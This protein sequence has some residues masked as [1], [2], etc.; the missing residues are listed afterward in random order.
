MCCFDGQ[1]RLASLLDDRDLLALR[2]VSPKARTWVDAVMHK[3]P[4]NVFT[5]YVNEVSD[6]DIVNKNTVLD[7]L[8]DEETDRI[9]FFRRLYISDSSFFSHPLIPSFLCT[10]GVQIHTVVRCFCHFYEYSVRDG[11]EAEQVAFYQALPN[12]TQLSTRWLGDRIPDGKMPA[13][14]RLQLR[15]LRCNYINRTGKLNFDFLQQLPNLSHFWL[16]EM[17]VEAYV[18]VLC[19]LGSY[20]EAVNK[21][22]VSCGRTRTIF[23]D[24]DCIS[25]EIFHDEWISNVRVKRLLRELAVADG[26]IL[27]QNMPIQLLDEAIRLFRRQRGGNL[28][29][30]SFGKC[31]RSLYGFSSSLYEVELPNMRKL[32]VTGALGGTSKN[33]DYS[34]TVRWPKLKNVKVQS[35]PIMADDVSYIAKLVFGSGVHRPSVKR[36]H[37]DMKTLLSLDSNEAH[38]LLLNFPNLTCLSLWMEEEEDVGLFHSLMGMLPTCCPKIRFSSYTPLFFWGTRTSLEFM[39][40]VSTLLLLPCYSSQASK[41]FTSC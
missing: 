23:V 31:I 29:L 15:R 27:I 41:W 11:N 17:R 8:M 39:R 5:L 40:K 16:P 19:A 20:F 32:E 18:K 25:D 1:E 28:L 37:F 12:L 38:L 14:E 21:G 3:H 26:R 36:L 33:G 2:L 34:R 9:P 30:S 7:R 6:E 13:L 24:L 22:K 4:S 10:Y 35:F